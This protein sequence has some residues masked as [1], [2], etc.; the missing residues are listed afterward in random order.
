VALI[1]NFSSSKDDS[2]L[3]NTEM[4][5]FD[6]LDDFMVLPFITIVPR[7]K[8]FQAK[9]MDTMNVSF[10]ISKKGHESFN[11][12]SMS[13]ESYITYEIY[14]HDILIKGS[15]GKLILTDEL[16]ESGEGNI[17]IQIPKTPD[18]YYFGLSIKTGVNPP[19]INSYKYKL[20]VE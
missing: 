7:Q 9:P 18:I 4:V 19:T 13:V 8:Y 20:V 16:I 15:S 6:Y 3:T 12:D 10:E 14:S 2:L 5:Y 1:H 17:K 11:I